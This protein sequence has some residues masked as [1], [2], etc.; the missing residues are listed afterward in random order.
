MNAPRAFHGRIFGRTLPLLPHSLEK[1]DRS[2]RDF[3]ISPRRSFGG[4]LLG[5]QLAGVTFARIAK[6]IR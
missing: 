1:N 3:Q 6:T 4:N 5:G 2:G